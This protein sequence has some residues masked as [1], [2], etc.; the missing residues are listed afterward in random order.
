MRMH[1]HSL[2][3]DASYVPKGM[4]EEWKKKDP[5]VLFEKK[6][7]SEGVLTESSRN[8]MRAKLI[9]EI[10]EAVEYAVAQPYPVGEQ[11]AEGVFAE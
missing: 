5:V 9:A 8:E 11:A 4:V 1:G 3:D 7:L 6:L 10:D 2:S